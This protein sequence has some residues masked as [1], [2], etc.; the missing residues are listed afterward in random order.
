[1]P[2]T[3]FV[4]P[5]RPSPGTGFKPTLKILEAE[6]GE[7]YSQPTPDGINHMRLELNLKWDALTEDQMIEI[8][9]FFEARKGTEPFYYRPVGYRIALKWTCA[10][11]DGSIDGVWRMSAKFKQSF[12][13]QV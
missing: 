2:L 6:F 11:W 8:R 13:S 5:V 1:M 10:E 12:T 3:T 4:P 7:G 9:E